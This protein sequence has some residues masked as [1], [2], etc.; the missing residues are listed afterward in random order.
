MS[1]GHRLLEP[2]ERLERGLAQRDFRPTRNDDLFIRRLTLPV[3]ALGNHSVLSFS[4]F[5]SHG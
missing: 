4:P 1:N 2:V 5:L 3:E